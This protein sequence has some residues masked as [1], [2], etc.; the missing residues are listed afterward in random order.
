MSSQ[1]ITTAVVIDGRTA[2]KA[3][4]AQAA[5]IVQEWLERRRSRAELRRLLETITDRDLRDVGISR[6]EMVRESVKPF[7]RP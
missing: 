1:S 5:V 4:L 6:Y 7:W 3:L 2:T